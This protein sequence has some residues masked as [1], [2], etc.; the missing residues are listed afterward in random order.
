MYFAEMMAN[1][2]ILQV[3]SMF[4]KSIN[5][6]SRSIT[7]CGKPIFMN[8]VSLILD[9]VLKILTYYTCIVNKLV[10]KKGN[11]LIFHYYL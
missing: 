9:G 5:V 3:K 8:V 4:F 2:G 1:L 11:N 6:Y 10:F 7:V